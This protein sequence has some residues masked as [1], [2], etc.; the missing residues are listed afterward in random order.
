MTESYNRPFGFEP[1]ELKHDIVQDLI[2]QA[3]EKNNSIY[4]RTLDTSR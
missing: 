4:H 2:G 3:D 1:F